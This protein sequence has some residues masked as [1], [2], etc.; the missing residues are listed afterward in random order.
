M[1]TLL[2]LLLMF[3][4]DWPTYNGDFSGRRYSTLD[5]INQSNV[6]QL[7]VAWVAT[8]RTT[9]I[10]S[11]PLVV[12]GIMYWTTP[13]NVWAMDARSGRVIWHYYRESQGDHIGQRGVGMY[14][15]WLYFETPDCHLISLNAKDGTVRWDIELADPKLGYFATMAP[16]V[17]RD[18]VLAGVSGD[19]TDIPGFLVSIDPVTGKV[20]WKWFSEPKPGEPGSDTWPKGT[21]AITHGG[22]MTWITGTYDPQLNLTYWGT[23]NP[24]PVLNG[25][26]RPGD[27]LYTCSIVALD[28]DTGK[29]KWYFQP[30]P[31]DTHDWDAAQTP[32]LFEDTK[33]GVQRKLIAQASRNGYFFVLDRSTGEHI[34]TKPF[35]ATNWSVGIDAHGQPRPK[36]EKEPKPDGALVSP[37]SDGAT[38]WMA[39]SYDPGSGLYFISARRLWS[40]FYMTA[41]SKPEGWAGR[42]RNLWAESVIEGIDPQTG[43]VRWQHEIGE[44][45]GS[46]GILTT[47]GK[48]LFTED[49]SDNLMAL[50]PATGKTLWHVPIGGRMVASPMTFELEGRQYLITAIENSIFAWV[51]PEGR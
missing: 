47:A 39:P 11:T 28:P 32:I 48:L 44:G 13:D 25:D 50:D 18:H 17:I 40:E 16:L 26:T 9:A 37:G 12:K 45:E 14:Q 8:L 1:N 29:L 43:E 21:D 38:N 20:Q 15:D 46:A 36:K 10:K 24:Q 7:T 23:G 22:G 41:E 6:K 2:A 34:L 31:H 30:S 4:S 3:A 27:N 5:Q 42:D 33:N 51:V 19:V 49:N 35:I